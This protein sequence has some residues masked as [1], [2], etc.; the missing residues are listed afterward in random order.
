[1]VAAGPAARAAGFVSADHTV[2]AHDARP[3]P[4]KLARFAVACSVCPTKTAVFSD[5]STFGRYIR[6]QSALTAARASAR[7]AQAL[8]GQAGEAADPALQQRVRELGDA[9]EA[10]ERDR[11]LV[12]RGERGAS[13]P[14]AAQTGG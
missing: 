6:L 4:A 8:L 13:A 7:L 14:V 9:L 3:L 2:P 12:A 10:D 5:F 11:I 1:M